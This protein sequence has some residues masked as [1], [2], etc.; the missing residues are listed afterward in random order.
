MKKDITFVILI[1]FAL[2]VLIT[3]AAYAVYVGVTLSAVKAGTAFLPLAF[4]SFTVA[5]I[6][7]NAALVPV[8][9]SYAF[10]RRK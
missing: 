10:L 1:I 3:D 7:V 9:L 8:A 2:A 6:A 5:V 4:R